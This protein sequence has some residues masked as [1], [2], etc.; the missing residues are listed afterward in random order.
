MLQQ[1]AI[2]LTIEPEIEDGS[3]FVPQLANLNDALGRGWRVV[4]ATP[5]GGMGYSAGGGVLC[6]GSSFLACL[7]IVQREYDDDRESQT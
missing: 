2:V 3:G 1:R 4:S 6:P 5:F 7:V